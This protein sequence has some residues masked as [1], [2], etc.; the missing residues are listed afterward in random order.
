MEGFIY[1]NE[2]EIAWELLIVI[3]PYITGLV[4]GA[5]IVSSLYHVF[6]IK[7]LKPVARFSLVT[8]LAFLLVSPLPLLVHLGHPER[9]LEMYF[10]PNLVSAMAGFGYIWLLYLLLVLVEVWLVFRP[11][12]VGYAKSSKGFRKTIYSV[13]ALGVYDVSEKSLAIDKKLIRVLAFI[14]IPAAVVLHGYV[15]FIFG[16]VKANPWWSTPL[17]PII[18]LGSAIVSGIALLIVM[19]VIVTKIRKAPLDHACLR[20]MVLWLVGFLSINLVLE[21]LEVFS[22][23]YESEESWGIVLQLVTEK[24]AISYFGIQFL[25]GSILPLFILG[26]VLMVK[27]RQQVKTSLAFLA[28]ALALI[29]VFAMRWNIVIGGQ[30]ISKSLRGFSSYNP[31]LLGLEGILVAAVFML[32]P[33]V[34]FAVLIYLLPLWQEEEK[35]PE[36]RGLS[37]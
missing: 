33:F 37:F 26:L 9:A 10:R 13:L 35:L 1:P 2:S 30:M 36:K 12:I 34:V 31:S 4:A 8:A 25:M 19:Y 24:I 29:G 21:G 20:S 7:A 15:G 23:Y 18:F 27:W 5:F 28:S 16:A 32:L 14:G 22:M 17:M 3:Y 6:G 11:D